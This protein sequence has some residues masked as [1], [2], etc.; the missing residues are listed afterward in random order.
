MLPNKTAVTYRKVL[1]TLRNLGIE[2]VETF[3]CDY[4][5]SV[6]KAI[7]SVYPGVKIEGCDVHWKRSLRSKQAKI[8]LL[9]HSDD[10]I[11][12]QNWIRMLWILSLVPVTDVLQ[13]Y[14]QYVLP[15]MPEVEEEDE[16]QDDE[17]RHFTKCMNDYLD[18]FERTWV[19]R[20]NPRTGVRG[21][22]LFK[23]E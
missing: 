20:V 4:E 7:T 9:R 8:G 21:H 17:S 5:Q 16:E 19:G 14:T 23:L 15:K 13:V 10:S 18:Y 11:T 6:T 2:Q 3:H 22:L 12:I 1:T